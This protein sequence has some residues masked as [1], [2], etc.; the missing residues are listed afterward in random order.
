MDEFR[1]ITEQTVQMQTIRKDRL[2]AVAQQQDLL[3]SIEATA[4]DR[5]ELADLQARAAVLGVRGAVYERTTTTLD[6]F[7]RE[8]LRLTEGLPEIEEW[9]D[10]AGVGDLL[11][12][13]RARR[14]E[15][16][17]AL[18][19][20]VGIVERA[21][22]EVRSLIEKNTADRLTIDES[23]R[24]SRRA[25]DELQ[26]G[27]GALTRKVEDLTEREAQLSALED[28][29]TDRATK[30]AEL[31]KRRRQVFAELEQV[32]AEQFQSRHPNRE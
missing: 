3:K 12:G 6:S 10:R 17:H 14:T 18:S 16:A 20:V 26:A 9:S 22:T 30:V 11:A 25:L 8:L 32:R 23:A 27:A 29:A 1:S 4:K 21:E 19:I 15:A 24:A 13:V 5:E 31:Q 2:D 28:L 7:R